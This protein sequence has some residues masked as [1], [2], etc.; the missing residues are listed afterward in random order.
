MTT[1]VHI[2]KH[3]WDVKIDRSTRFGNPFTHIADRQ[4]KALMTVD[5]I[6]VA[7]DYYRALMEDGKIFLESIGVYSGTDLFDRLMEV[8]DY[9][10]SNLHKLKGKRLAC[11]CKD[12][13][14]KPCHGDILVEL[15]NKYCQ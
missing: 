7:L 4:T 11:W 14:T 10:M 3:Q 12:K 6:G 2:K 8:R 5:N 1:V 9:T 13:P 15:V